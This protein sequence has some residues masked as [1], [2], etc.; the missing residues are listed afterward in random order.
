VKCRSTV[1]KTNQCSQL[2]SEMSHQSIP[3]PRLHPRTNE[4]AQSQ[5]S[6]LLPL[7]SPPEPLE[8]PALPCPPRDPQFTDTYTVTTHLIPAAFPR[9][10]PFIPVP[11]LPVHESRAER[12]SRVQRYTSELLSLQARNG[13]DHSGKQPTVLWTVLN[14]YVR[15]GSGGGLTLLVLH[16]NGLHK[17][18]SGQRTSH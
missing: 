7:Q 18:V 14:R 15:A 4:Q 3:R 16:S 12:S 1:L 2:A 9:A 8:F 11:A 5:P 6:P 10:S 13:P 17:E